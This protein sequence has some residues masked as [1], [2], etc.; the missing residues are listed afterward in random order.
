[1]GAEYNG[2]DPMKRRRAGKFSGTVTRCARGSCVTDILQHSSLKSRILL[3]KLIITQLIINSPSHMKPVSS[4]QQ[5]QQF[6]LLNLILSQV[7]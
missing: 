6:T 2:A 7:N 5:P 1:M 3:E 4:L